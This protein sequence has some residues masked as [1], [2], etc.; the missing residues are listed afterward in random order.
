MLI[1]AYMELWL[2]YGDT[3]VVLDIK[4]ENVMDLIDYNEEG[5]SYEKIKELLSSINLKDGIN[6]CLLASDY[7][8]IDVLSI[9]N[10]ILESKGVK[11]DIYMQEQL[12]DR[13]KGYK[14]KALDANIYDRSNTI[15]ISNTRFDPIFGYSGSPVYIARQDKGLMSGIIKSIKEPRSGIYTKEL[16]QAYYIVNHYN[17]KA[18]EVI[19]YKDKIIDIIIDNPVDANKKAIRVLDRLKIKHEKAKA[20]IIGSGAS[21]TLSDALYSLW[22]CYRVLRDNSNVILL[23]EGSKGLGARALERFIADRLD[24]YAEGMEDI[25]LLNHAKSRYDISLITS[26]PEYYAKVLGIKAYRS[27]NL[28]LKHSIARNQKQ[29]FLIVNDASNILLEG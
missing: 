3:E 29:K 20:I 1:I 17:S 18:I 21:Y 13:Y 22:N 14:P 16:E 27:I 26:L 8:L 23:A 4:A 9:L 5:L 11:A 6:I 19:T 25:I 2:R 15:L 10:D 24:D 28:A 7:K 12:I